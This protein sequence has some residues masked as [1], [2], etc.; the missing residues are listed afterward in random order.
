MGTFHPR[1]VHSSAYI[2]RRPFE[3][4]CNVVV[5]GK[6]RS[7]GDVINPEPLYRSSAQQ[8]SHH[9]S[10]PIDWVNKVNFEVNIELK[11]KGGGRRRAMSTVSVSVASLPPSGRC[12]TFLRKR[13]P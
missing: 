3:C 8:T 12:D 5:A 6:S 4:R 7:D 2:D 9:P 1:S 11:R 10:T 13:S